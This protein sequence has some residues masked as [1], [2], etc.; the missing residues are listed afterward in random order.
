MVL[1]AL[2]TNLAEIAIVA[3]AAIVGHNELAVGNIL[4]GIAVQTVVP[5]A[6]DAFGNQGDVPLATRAVS[7]ELPFGG[8]LVISVLSIVL[9]G[10]FMPT[11][12]ILLRV[13]PVGAL[14]AIVWLAT[15]ML[16]RRLRVHTPRNSATGNGNCNCSAYRAAGHR[17]RRHRAGH[18]AQL[19]ALAR[20]DVRN[21]AQCAHEIDQQGPRRTAARRGRWDS[22]RHDSQRHSRHSERALPQRAAFHQVENDR[23][24]DQDVNRR[25]HHA[26]DD[27]RRDGLHDV[28]SHS[29]APHDRD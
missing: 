22:E 25:R 9:L 3:S 17:L 28:R 20:H 27:W 1:L 24:D 2:A 23:R 8:L 13:T 7:S 21:N 14:I 6:F 18:A 16:L 19:R 10:H 11:N 29:R 4:G 12:L 5:A 15:L 26:A